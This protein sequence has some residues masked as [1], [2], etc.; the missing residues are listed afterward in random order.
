[1]ITEDQRRH[2]HGLQAAL[3]D[4]HHVHRMWLHAAKG[5]DRWIAEGRIAERAIDVRVAARMAGVIPDR[6]Y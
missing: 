3:Q 4:L 5:K 1:M 6:F 2:L